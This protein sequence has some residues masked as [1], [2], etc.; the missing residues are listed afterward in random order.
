MNQTDLEARL[1]ETEARLAKAEAR[2]DAFEKRLRD[3]NL[4]LA[5]VLA[6]M[7]IDIIALGVDGETN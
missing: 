5:K 6:E 2:G 4:E 1:S 3:Q 7:Q